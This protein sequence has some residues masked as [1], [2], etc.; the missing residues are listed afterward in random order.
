MTILNNIESKKLINAIIKDNCTEK[1]TKIKS[2][3][4]K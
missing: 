4:K 2:E 3:N 1:S